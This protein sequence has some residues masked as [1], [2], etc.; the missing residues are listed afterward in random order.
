[1]RISARLRWIVCGLER[2]VPPSATGVTVH[3]RPALL[4]LLALT[5]TL[6]FWPAPASASRGHV[7]AGVT[8][9]EPCKAG[10]EPCPAGKLKEPSGVA[11]SEAMGDVYVI[12]AGNQ[13]VER[14]N[15]KGEV[16]SE[17]TGPHA[18]GTGSFTENSTTVT[19]ASASSGAF[20][21]GEELSALGAPGLFEAGTKITAVEAEGP[22]FKLTLSKAAKE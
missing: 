15:A 2:E 16:Q 9:G 18:E 17:L 7:F 21:A 1:M 10:E 22:N 13:R 14:F 6:A 4:T 12:D 11:V 20:T 8:I 3:R 5:A 19:G